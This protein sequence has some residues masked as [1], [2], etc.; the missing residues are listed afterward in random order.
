MRS[1]DF[2][3]L[4]P[5]EGVRSGASIKVGKFKRSLK[6]ESAPRCPGGAKL[7]TWTPFAR[8]YRL[9]GPS[10]K[11][12]DI[13]QV[14]DSLSAMESSLSRTCSQSVGRTMFRSVGIVE[15]SPGCRT[16]L[17]CAWLI[18]NCGVLASTNKVM[19]E[20]S[21]QSG[22]ELGRAWG[23][24]WTND[25][26]S[27]LSDS[28]LS[29]KKRSIAKVLSRSRCLL[30]SPSSLRAIKCC[31]DS[32]ICGIFTWNTSTP[33][34]LASGCSRVTL[35]Q[36]GMASWFSSSASADCKKDWKLDNCSGT[37]SSPK[38]CLSKLDGTISRRCKHSAPSQM[39]SSL[40]STTSPSHRPRSILRKLRTVALDSSNASVWE[41]IQFSQRPEI[42]QVLASVRIWTGTWHTK[43]SPPY[44]V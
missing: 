43:L 31:P 7:D 11:C 15:S 6:F 12:M 35:K 27:L 38:F 37:S 42:I 30:I 32:P 18:S 14:A 23:T 34:G 44:R 21:V 33:I 5:S 26:G 16:K 20:S 10:C 28:L 36:A 39:R 19:S 1:R 2:I 41:V 24:R 9:E 25:G 29:T 3:D 13:D 40:S 4:D 17:K 22:S 8:L